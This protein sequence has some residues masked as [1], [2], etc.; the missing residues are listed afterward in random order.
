MVYEY[1]YEE[2]QTFWDNWDNIL[3]TQPRKVS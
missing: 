1:R 3:G 2:Q